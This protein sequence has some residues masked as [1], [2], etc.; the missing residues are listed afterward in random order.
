MKERLERR[1]ADNAYFHPDFHGALSCGIEY[2]DAQYGA[3]AVRGTCGPLRGPTTRRCARR[4][5]PAGWP[6]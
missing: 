3:E 1:A 5:A 4:S 6:R 2:L